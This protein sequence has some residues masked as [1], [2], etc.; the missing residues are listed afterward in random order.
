M[1][2]YFSWVL[3][4]NVSFL[5]TFHLSLSIHRIKIS[6]EILNPVFNFSHE[7]TKVYKFLSFYVALKSNINLLLL[8]LFSKQNSSIILPFKYSWLLSNVGVRSASPYVVE[9]AHLSSDFQKNL[10][11]TYYWFMVVNNKI[12]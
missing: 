9:N 3:V 1:S 10:L 6:K 12:N 5:V 2:L 7:E 11:L 4:H 8:Q